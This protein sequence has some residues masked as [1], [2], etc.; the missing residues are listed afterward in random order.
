MINP[1]IYPLGSNGWIPAN[2]F[3]TICF[4]FFHEDEL[5]VLDA[6]TGLSRLLE[7]KSS[8][9]SSQWKKL[10]AVRVFLSHYHLDHI[11]GL[12][13]GRAL[14]DGIPLTVYGPGQAVYGKTAS[15]LLNSVFAKPYSPKPFSELIEGVTIVDLDPPGI[16]VGGINI[17]VKLNSEHSDPS[18]GLRFNDWF[19]YVTDTPPENETIEFIKGVKLLLHESYY[20]SMAQ[21]KDKNDD[22]SIHTSGPHT[23]TLG[24]GLIA[25]RAGVE[26]LVLIHHNPEFSLRQVEAGA[27][28]VRDKLN[29]DC[30]IARDLEEI[31]IP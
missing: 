22:L 3:E 10:K 26:K 31:S 6:G 29:I 28:N 5:F 21:F 8:L 4:A 2:N 19:A 13:W 11:L 1:T 25:K 18:V 7:L 20:D 27:Q 16:T 23:G 17:K 12:F 30:V 9:F 15:E 14:F 24:A